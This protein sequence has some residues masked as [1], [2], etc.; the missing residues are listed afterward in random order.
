LRKAIDPWLKASV[1]KTP[2][3]PFQKTVLAER[4]TFVNSSI[5]C[6]PM[7]KPA[8]SSGIPESTE[9]TCTFLK[10]SFEGAQTK[11]TGK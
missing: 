9:T 8:R 3:G 11:S 7:S 2:G 1:S 10:S 5:D 6:G 4:M